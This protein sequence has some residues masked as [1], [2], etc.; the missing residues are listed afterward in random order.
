VF[1]LDK[2]SA[3]YHLGASSDSQHNLQAGAFLMLKTAEKI[4][5]MRIPL[6]HLGGGLSLDK[7][8]RLF[9]YK[10]G[11]SSISNDFYI[12]RRIHN[13]EVYN[14]LSASWQ[15]KTGKKPDILLH[16]HY[17]DIDANI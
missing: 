7:E 16:Y 14:A 10:S 4:G 6:L 17:G 3:H 12:G 15:K 11:F 1:L 5:Q 2:N 8:D 9:R 13:A